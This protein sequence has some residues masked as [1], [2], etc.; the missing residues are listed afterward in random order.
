MDCN[1]NAPLPLEIISDIVAVLVVLLL[2][3]E[4]FSLFYGQIPIGCV[5]ASAFVVITNPFVITI[6]VI[7]LIFAHLA[8]FCCF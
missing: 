5:M 8:N 7:P 4:S 6:H 3:M 2:Q 1:I